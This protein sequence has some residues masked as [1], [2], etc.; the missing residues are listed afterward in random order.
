[1]IA[2]RAGRSFFTGYPIDDGQRGRDISVSWKDEYR[3]GSLI[4]NAGEMFSR[5]SVRSNFKFQVS[6]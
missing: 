2:S 6:A 1:M 4:E 5:I 3:F